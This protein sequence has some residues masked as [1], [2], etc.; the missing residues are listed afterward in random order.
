MKRRPRSM[1]SAIL[2]AL[3]GFGTYCQEPRL[4]A[5]FEHSGITYKVTSTSPDPFEVEVVA[6]TS[7]QR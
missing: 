7:L 3:M 4:N 5:E 1:L 6:S 2:M